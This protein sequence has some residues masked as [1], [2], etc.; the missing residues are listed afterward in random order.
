MSVRYDSGK[1]RRHTLSS[2][3]EILAKSMDILTS[4][5]I[6]YIS[7]NSPTKVPF[8]ER[9]TDDTSPRTSPQKPNQEYHCYKNGAGET[10]SPNPSLMRYGLLREDVDGF[11]AEFTE[12]AA[13]WTI[14]DWKIPTYSYGYCD[15]ASKPQPKVSIASF[16]AKIETQIR[17]I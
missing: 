12:K 3:D 10:R 14:V 1:L 6:N 2:N 11:L 17:A 9:S 8:V 13:V 16:K 15:Q 5:L 4:N 7:V